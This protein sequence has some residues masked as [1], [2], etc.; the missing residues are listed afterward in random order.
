MQRDSDFIS[1]LEDT[2]GPQPPLMKDNI[3][4]SLSSYRMV[5]MRP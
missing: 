3:H 2:I 5:L 1:D 4:K